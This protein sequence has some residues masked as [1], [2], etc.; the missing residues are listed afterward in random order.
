MYSPDSI[1]SSNNSVKNLNRKSSWSLSDEDK[2]TYIITL[3]NRTGR[4][5]GRPVIVVRV[6]TRSYL[7]T[8]VVTAVDWVLPDCRK[9]TQES[10]RGDST[11]INLVS[12]TEKR[13]KPDLF[14]LFWSTPSSWFLVR[15]FLFIWC[16]RYFLFISG[17]D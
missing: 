13:F 15:P 7:L 6:K 9:Q 16:N 10:I 3:T 11:D 2:E 14:S 12:L 1:N 4:G 5:K 17:V 8:V